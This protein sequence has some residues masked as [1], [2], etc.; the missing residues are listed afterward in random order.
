M[1]FFTQQDK[2]RR[3]TGVLVFYFVVAVALIITA[4][5]FG[6]AAGLTYGRIKVEWWA[7][8]WNPYLFAA[9]AGGVLLVVGG[10]TYYKVRQLSGPGSGRRVAELLGARPVSPD[11]RDINERK[12]LNVVEEMAIASGTPVPAVYI[13][14]EGSINAF[15]AGTSPSTAVVAVTRAATALLSREELQGV[16]AH[17][18]SHI[19][20]GD[21][22]LN[23]RLI[24]VLNG[25]IFIAL[26]GAFIL[27]IFFQGRSGSR[28][29]I[30]GGS[31]KGKGGAGAVILVILVVAIVITVV[32]YIGEF[33]ARLIQMAV[34]R[35]REFLADASAVQFT[36]NP[37]GIA[38]ALKKVGGLA[39]GSLIESPH[40]KAVGHLFFAD[41]IKHMFSSIMST[42]PDLTTRIK[43][44]D[45]YWNGSYPVVTMPKLDKKE[46]AAAAGGDEEDVLAGI[47]ISKF[48]QP[49]RHAPAVRA[50]PAQV[51][52][53]VGTATPQHVQAAQDLIDGLP[54]AYVKSGREPFGARAV[55]FALLIDP[56]EEIRRTQLDR[57]KGHTDA[58]VY[59]EV[60]RLVNDGQAVKPE[61]R[62]PLL[63]L[64]MPALRS[65]S[66]SQADEFFSNLDFLIMADNTVTMFEMS[67]RY[68][69]LRQYRQSIGMTGP[70]GKAVSL[71]AVFSPAMQLLSML[72][73]FGNGQNRECAL[74]AFAAGA[75]RIPGAAAVQPVP[76]DSLRPSQL[77]AVLDALA[78]ATPA[79][80]K[81][82]ID[83]CAS[84]I[85]AD[86][87]V[88]AEEADLIRVIGSAL[89]CPVPLFVPTKKNDS[90]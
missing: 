18:F 46:L 49:Q 21:M 41:G 74:A 54:A 2:A 25:I 51:V 69:V 24:G 50:T 52:Q 43:R 59:Q 6:V 72:A 34:S 38:G 81:S 23:I 55:V 67:L 85:M 87:T 3:H 48:A 7:P 77:E 17:E 16:V 75:A 12:L 89:E 71:A 30:S 31:G 65:L 5:Y 63:A 53:A 76:F 80:K 8:L 79:A 66:R 84:C 47:S 88:T 28:I 86:R 64:A 90:I 19:F 9:V 27:R 33:F 10:A 32:G 1:D 58:E 39:T 29:R 40:A 73:W 22:R 37:G 44:I 11:T 56:S 45:P 15:A 70:S 78:V 14:E 4:I 82:I 68:L 83:A 60:V 61:H 62:L 26:V 42:H 35:Q 57:L 36:R 13:M 20:N